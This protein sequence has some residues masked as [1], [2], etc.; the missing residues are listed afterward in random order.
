MP[1]NWSESSGP[2][3][4]Y[5]Y[6]Y[7]YIYAY[8]CTKYNIIYTCDTF[9]KTNMNHMKHIYI[10]YNNNDNNNNVYIYIYHTVI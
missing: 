9:R 1:V 3:V 5:I 10:Y 6:T 2:Y 4:H 8:V 7:I